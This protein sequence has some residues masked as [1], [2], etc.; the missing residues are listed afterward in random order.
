MYEGVLFFQKN[1]ILNKCIIFAL[2]ESIFGLYLLSF[3]YNFKLWNFININSLISTVLFGILLYA[4]GKLLLIGESLSPGFIL[5]NIMLIWLGFALTQFSTLRH[6]SNKI[7]VDLE[8]VLLILI[9]TGIT[10]ILFIAT[11]GIDNEN[12]VTWLNLVPQLLII[13]IVRYVI[14]NFNFI[15]RKNIAIFNISSNPK[16]K[17]NCYFMVAMLLFASAVL[18]AALGMLKISQYISISVFLSLIIGI[19]KEFMFAVKN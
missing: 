14:V 1:D 18:M 6:L 3:N 4:T 2:V 17:L 15:F 19:Y 8:R 7:N 5:F 12:I 16:M 11:A 9:G 10:I 13:Y